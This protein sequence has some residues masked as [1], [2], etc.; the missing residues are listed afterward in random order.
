MN[1]FTGQILVSKY[2]S[3]LKEPGILGEIADSR[4]ED[5]MILGYL[6]WSES[7][8]ILKRMMGTYQMNR[9]PLATA[10]KNGVSKYI[11][12]NKIGNHGP[13]MMQLKE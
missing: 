9:Q 6:V 11:H 3:I 1:T 7:K 12:Q 4:T 13:T 8:K 5:K 10:G 2:H